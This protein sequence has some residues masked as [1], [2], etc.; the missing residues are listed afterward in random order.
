[1]KLFNNRTSRLAIS[2][3]GFTLLSGSALAESDTPYSFADWWNG[4]TVTGNW[5]G[6][7][8]TLEDNGLSFRINW[9]AN[10]LGIVSGGIQNRAGYDEEFVF[11]ANLDFAK[12]TRIDAIEGLSATGQVRWRD[13]DGV[14]KYSYASQG[15]A[16]STF[17]GGK[18]WRLQGAYLTYTTPEIFGVK[19]LFTLSGG[20][21]NPAD[22]FINQPESKF[23]LNNQ[24]TSGRGIGANGIPWGGSFSTWGGFAKVQPID[25]Y[26]LQ[27][28]LYMAYPQ[29][30]NTRNHG[31]AFQGYAQDP[32]LN[33]LYWLTETGFTP[34]I[35]DAKLP[36]RY[37]VGYL[38]WGNQNT[39]FFGQEYDSRSQFY[40]QA[41]QMV[42]REPSK[43]VEDAAPYIADGKSVASSKNF[44]EPVSTAKPKLNEQGLRVFNLINYAPKY[45]ATIPF[46]FQSGFIYQG[47]IPYR[48]DDQF[49]VAFAYGNYSYY[50]QVADTERGRPT[51]I[52]QAVLE[53]DY[54]VQINNWSYIQPSLQYILNP[55]ATDLNPNELVL[56]F[57]LGANF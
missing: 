57:Q 35:G 53:V 8:D 1:M 3:L 14:N 20:W 17:Q 32:S 15:F 34:K 28:G 47:L 50:K 56:G 51:Q 16:P 24:L 38:Y 45:N 31:L 30:S 52:Y 13:G 4:K 12:L 54:R 41:D 48:D 22:F 7:R 27:S 42:Y 33:G 44:K 23:F 40:F 9:K 2:A 55:G 49:G 18:Q 43:P 26:Y 10:V 11:R 19:K 29:A 39:S 36:G 37:A 46:Y 25:W 5:F 6:V 21:Q